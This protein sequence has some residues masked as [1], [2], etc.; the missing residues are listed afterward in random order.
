M[1]QFPWKRSEI[2][3]NE[4]GEKLFHVNNGSIYTGKNLSTGHAQ[5]CP[6]TLKQ[7][8][9]IF[10]IRSLPEWRTQDYNASKI[11]FEEL[12]VSF[13]VDDQIFHVQCERMKT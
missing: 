5:S 4:M 2:T 6:F 7:T 8:I 12:S 11:H 13:H 10:V 9:D 1:F 3:G